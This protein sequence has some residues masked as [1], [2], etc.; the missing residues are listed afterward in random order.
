MLSLRELIREKSRGVE[1]GIVD[2]VLALR[3]TFARQDS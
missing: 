3:D 2:C 1:R